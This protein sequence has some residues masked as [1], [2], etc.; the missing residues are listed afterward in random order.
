ML[1]DS[2][3][4]LGTVSTSCTREWHVATHKYEIVETKNE[5]AYCTTKQYNSKKRCLQK[6][7]TSTSLCL[8]TLHPVLKQQ[9]RFFVFEDT[10][11]DRGRQKYSPCK[12]MH[13][14]SCVPRLEDGY[15]EHDL[16]IWMFP[17]IVVPPNHPF[18]IG[19]SII[20]HPFWGTTIFGNTHICLHDSEL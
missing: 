4:T 11:V 15:V 14:Q 20:N 8:T 1:E 3:D 16:S 5:Q 13:L 18:L 6:Q 10:K 19:F 9:W 2:L 17:K 12:S 7:L